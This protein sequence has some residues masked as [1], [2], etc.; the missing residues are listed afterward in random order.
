MKMIMQTDVVIK[1]HRMIEIE[2]IEGTDFAFYTD[3]RNI[4]T[5]GEKRIE[6]IKNITSMENLISVKGLDKINDV[7]SAP[8]MYEGKAVI[9]AIH[10]DNFK[11]VLE[12]KKHITDVVE[13]LSAKSYPIPEDYMLALWNWG[14]YKLAD[15][16]Y[17]FI[18]LPIA[19]GYIDGSVDNETYD[20]EKLLE[21]LKND[22]NVVD[23]ENLSISSI[24]YYNA[25]EGKDKSIEF[26]YLVPTEIYQKVACMDSYTSHKYILEELIGAEKCRIDKE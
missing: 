18:S 23:K 24:P 8:K 10:K 9:V 16:S 2:E 17:D 1:T 19:F 25:Y 14:S 5:N 13:K 11:L 26:S 12:G 6:V 22:D 3:T 21:K 20:L 15:L 7:V 4:D